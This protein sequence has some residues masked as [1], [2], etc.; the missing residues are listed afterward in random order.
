MRSLDTSRILMTGLLLAVAVYPALGDEMWVMRANL[1]GTG[2]DSVIGAYSVPVA[3]A[4][5]HTAEKLYY[6]HRD[7]GRGVSR[8]NLD[9]TGEEFVFGSWAYGLEADLLHAKLYFTRLDSVQRSN[10]DGS[11]IETV[12]PSSWHFRS[13]HLGLDPLGGK[14]YVPENDIFYGQR[15][16]RGNLD[17][18]GMEVIIDGADGSG[19]PIALDL[20]NS[21]LYWHRSGEFM[22]AN[23]DGSEREAILA[24]D[25]NPQDMT[26]DPQGGKLY[27][28]SREFWEDTQGIYRS[29]LDG[30]GGERLWEEETWRIALDLDANE[31]YWTGIPEPASLSLLALGGLLAT[32]RRR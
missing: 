9:G 10:L 2:F 30:T 13:E 16:R 15:I 21:K 12:V 22:R 26:I 3:L 14:L 23:L 7:A 18:S 32:R 4:V 27:W 19:G 5:D 6:M 17:G 31:M 25:G 1:D 20:A 28:T 24:W 8:C 29:N 11:N